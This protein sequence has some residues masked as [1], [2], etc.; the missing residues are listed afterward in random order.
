[1]PGAISTSVLTSSPT[2]SNC[3]PL[4]TAPGWRKRCQPGL[5]PPWPCLAPPPPAGSPRARRQSCDDVLLHD[6]V[7]ERS[8][9]CC[10]A[11]QAVVVW[12]T[13][14]VTPA[15]TDPI[16]PIQSSRPVRLLALLN[17]FSTPNSTLAPPAHLVAHEDPLNS[18]L[19][20]FSFSWVV[21][22]NTQPGSRRQRAT[23]RA[24]VLCMHAL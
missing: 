2:P 16:K 17:N 6:V 8:A 5:Y 1:M 9:V 20:L 18:L 23:C 19:L 11:V 22:K 4:F 15:R 14:C 21:R 12:P 7:G 10:F 3:R 13:N 24:V